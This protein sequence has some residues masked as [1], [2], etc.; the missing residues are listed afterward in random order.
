[1][2]NVTL[3]FLTATK[4][5][6]LFFRGCDVRAVCMFRAGSTKLTFRH[7]RGFAVIMSTSQLAVGRTGIPR[8]VWYNELLSSGE[9]LCLLARSC[10]GDGETLTTGGN[11]IY[12]LL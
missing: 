9:W 2:Q 8:T 6:T 11:C 7:A 1:V 10:E 4:M 12:H 3:E 5:A